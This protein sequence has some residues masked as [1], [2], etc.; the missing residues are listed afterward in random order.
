MRGKNPQVW[1]QWQSCPTEYALFCPRCS[2][3]SAVL[4]K[5]VSNILHNMLYFVQGIQVSLQCCPRQCPTSST[6]SRL[7]C[8]PVLVCSCVCARVKWI[9]LQAKVEEATCFSGVGSPFLQHSSYLVP[10]LGGGQNSRTSYSWNR[11]LNAF[12]VV[13]FIARVK[14]PLKVS[15]HA[16]RFSRLVWS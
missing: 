5:V 2:G 13:G 4:S 1:T 16:P 14:Q 3:E 9:E 11:T 8:G 12:W 10:G 6:K 7:F 15:L